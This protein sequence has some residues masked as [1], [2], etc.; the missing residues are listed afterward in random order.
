ML[1]NPQILTNN[2]KIVNPKIVI[3]ISVVIT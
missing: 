1:K 2:S 3:A